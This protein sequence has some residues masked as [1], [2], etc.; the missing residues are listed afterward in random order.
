MEALA[1]LGGLDRDALHSQLAAAVH[2]VLAMERRPEGRRLAHIGLLEGNP[3]VPELIWSIDT[4]KGPGY[5][6]F[7]ER[8][9]VAP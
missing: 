4:G 2:V 9:G 5:G 7:A 8:L 3:V 6:D 1:G